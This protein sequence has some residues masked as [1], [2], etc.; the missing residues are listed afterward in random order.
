MRLVTFH[1]GPGLTGAS[2][3][4]YIDDNSCECVYPPS[5]ATQSEEHPDSLN[6]FSSSLL[7]L[8]MNAYREETI[9]ADIPQPIFPL[10]LSCCHGNR[11]RRETGSYRPPSGLQSQSPSLSLSLSPSLSVLS[12]PV[13]PVWATD[14][15]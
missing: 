11:S 6:L 2:R 10:T 12:E 8:C 1:L 14:T 3:H 7:S 15:R 5:N 9:D 4:G 13:A